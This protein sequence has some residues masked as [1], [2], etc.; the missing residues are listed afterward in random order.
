MPLSTKYDCLIVGAGV[1]GLA[2][3]Y[4]LARFTDLK[5]IG[6]LELGDRVAQGNSHARHNSQSLHHG[7][8]ETNYGLWESRRA[9]RSA[10]MLVNYATALP[11]RD[12]DRI[13]RR[14][15]RMLLGVG[16]AECAAVRQRFAAVRDLYPRLQLLERR[17]IAD[18]EPNVALIEG[19]WRR[20][21]IVALGTPDDYSAVDFA[22]LAESFSHACVRLDRTTDKQVTQLFSTHVERI[23]RDGDDYVLET[24]RGL[25][26][27]RSVAV[28]AGVHSLPMAQALGLGLDCACLPMA[29]SF[30]FI[31]EALNGKVYT[32]QDNRLPFPAVHGDPDLKEPGKTRFGPT[33]LV[34]PLLA[35]HHRGRVAEFL[36][37]LKLNH[38]PL[39]TIRDGLR[40]PALRR[41]LLHNLLL[42]V[43]GL[44]RYRFAREVRKIVPSVT[45]A[46]LGYAEG[47]GGV[48]PLLI[49]RASGALHPDQGKLGDG[50]GLIFNLAPPSAESACLGHG[51]TDMRALA[52]HLGARI[53]EGALARELL[54]GDDGAGE[55][56]FA[57]MAKAG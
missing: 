38:H 20:D 34:L 36:R 27:A 2:L 16:A 41:H 31:P 37:V 49:D 40:V 54:C 15:P 6:L 3:L 39:G 11:N 50:Q 43:P 46:D 1:T 45:T 44:N 12:R 35:R 21:E 5:R 32:L 30:Y 19:T 26:Q 42:E 14:M 29:G 7:D 13:L 24:S 33:A 22:A 51:E 8:I 23:R 25:L 10:A 48:R 52:R 56:E 18:L 47:C 9:A 55:D 53:D 57:G 28:C 17:A 4:Q